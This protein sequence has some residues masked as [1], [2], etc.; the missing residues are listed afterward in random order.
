MLSKE[1][2]E[3]MEEV[4]KEGRT[5]LFV[6]H[7]MAAMSQLCT[8]I[9]DQKW[10]YSR[11]WSNAKIIEAYHTNK[12]TGVWTSPTQTRGSK[13]SPSPKQEFLTHLVNILL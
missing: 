11:Q 5:V 4:G 10:H 2:F 9:S 1:V 12:V 7:S 13:E 3:K 8:S 6:S